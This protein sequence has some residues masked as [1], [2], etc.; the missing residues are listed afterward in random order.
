MNGTVRRNP[1][2]VGCRARSMTDSLRGREMKKKKDRTSSMSIT[3]SELSDRSSQWRQMG[4]APGWNIYSGEVVDM[5]GARNSVLKGK[6]WKSESS[7]DHQNK[8]SI[9]NQDLEELRFW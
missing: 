5:S 6:N 1:D 9:K 4:Q 3:F 7:S 8:H 2:S